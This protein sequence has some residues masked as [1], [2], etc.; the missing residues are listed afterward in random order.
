MRAFQNLPWGRKQNMRTSPTAVMDRMQPNFSRY[1]HDSTAPTNASTTQ[2]N[3]SA[4]TAERRSQPL[5]ASV[6]EPAWNRYWSTFPPPV[7]SRS[8]PM[9]FR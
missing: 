9:S 1:T 4:G 3:H 7:G 5:S 6:S 2:K 8:Q